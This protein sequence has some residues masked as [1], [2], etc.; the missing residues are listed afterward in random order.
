MGHPLPQHLRH[1]VLNED[2]LKLSFLFFCFRLL[3]HGSEL[4]ASLTLQRTPAGFHELF[5]GIFFNP[6]FL[7]LGTASIITLSVSYWRGLFHHRNFKRNKSA[8]SLAVCQPC[9][10]VRCAILYALF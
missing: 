3:R 10:C 5:R 1:S 8:I 2:E 9:S 6:Q 4:Q 7:L